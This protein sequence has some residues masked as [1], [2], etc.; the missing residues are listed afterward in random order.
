M[1]FRKKFSKTREAKIDEYYSQLK[2][3]CKCGHSLLMRPSETKVL[4]S[5]CGNYHYKDK[6]D[7]FKEKLKRKLKGD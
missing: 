5:H 2:V 7:E 1:G 6:K 3:Y 4:C